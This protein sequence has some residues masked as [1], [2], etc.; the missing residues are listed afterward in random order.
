[1]MTIRR[2]PILALSLAATGCA[3]GG[4]GGLGDI[5]TGGPAG[6]QA[7]G[8]TLTAEV[9]EVRTQQQQ[10]IVRTQS[11]EQGPVL[12]DQNTQVVYQNQQYQVTALERGDVVEM[13]IQEIQQGYY[14]DL[15]Q[16]V[17]SVQERQ[18]GTQSGTPAGVHRI[19]GTI[20]QIDLSRNMFTLN[21]TQGGTLPI[22]LPS[23]ASTADRER[24]RDYRSGDYVRVEVRAINEETGELVRWGWGG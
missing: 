24:L 15:I 20:D 19:E 10:I 23:S 16:V 5:L 14:T 9:Q 17:Q 7:G 6:G 11:G 8:G 18:G 21:M 4:L 2:F 13:R 3:G 1:M 22:Y 12:F